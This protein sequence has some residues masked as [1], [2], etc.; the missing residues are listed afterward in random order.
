MAKLAATC[1]T[2]AQTDCCC[3]FDAWTL[4]FEFVW[5]VSVMKSKLLCNTIEHL[6]S[7]CIR[8]D[9]MFITPHWS[10][11]GYESGYERRNFLSSIMF[12]GTKRMVCATSQRILLAKIALSSKPR[13]H[14][15]EQLEFVSNIA[16]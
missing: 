15:N 14:L 1:L 2:V 8:I 5:H 16:R 10:W 11:L 13:A 4:D 3:L 12:V 6:K 7:E 9:R